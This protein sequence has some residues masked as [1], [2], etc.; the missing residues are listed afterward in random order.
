MLFKA[1]KSAS[2]ERIRTVTVGVLVAHEHSPTT[3]YISEPSVIE[4]PVVM[5]RR[6]CMTPRAIFLE[7]FP[8]VRCGDKKEEA[9]R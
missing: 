1:L 5:K 2:A 4:S 6:I 9:Y 3:A 7:L 8:N